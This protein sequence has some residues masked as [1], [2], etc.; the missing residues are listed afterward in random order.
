MMQLKYYW[1]IV[2]T[3]AQRSDTWH[4]VADTLSRQVERIRTGEQK[5]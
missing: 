3:N 4:K 5:I 1:K 2:K